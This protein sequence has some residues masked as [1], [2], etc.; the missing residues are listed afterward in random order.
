MVGRTLGH[1]KILEPLGAGGMGEVYRARDSKLDRDVAIKVLPQDFAADAERLARFTREAKLLASLNHPGIAGVYGLEDE[2]ATCFIAMELVEGETLADRIARAG[3]IEVDEALEIARQIAAALEAAHGKGVI[4]RDL[5]PANVIVTKNGKA[6]V[7]DF[8]LAKALAAGGDGG[9]AD[10]TLSPTMVSAV[11]AAGMILGTAAY[12]SPEQARGQAADSRADVWSFGVV[13]FEMLSGKRLFPGDT[14]S[15]VLASVLKS[16]PEWNHLPTDLPAAVHRLLRRCLAKDSADRLHHIADARLDI[17]DAL[18][19]SSPDEVAVRVAPPADTLRTRFLPWT[20]AGVAILLAVATLWFGDLLSTAESGP[21][22]SLA[23]PFPPGTRMFDDQ[24]GALAVSPSGGHLA[25]VLFQDGVRK[26]FLR[27]LDEPGVVPLEGTEGAEMPFFSPDGRWLGF[28]ADGALRKVPVDGGTPLTVCDCVENNRGASWGTGDSIVFAPENATPLMMVSAGGGSPVTI[29]R[30]DEETGERTHRWPQVL[31]D[32]DA[33][34]FTVGYLDS[35]ESYEESPIDAVRISTGER[36]RILEG[37]SFAKYVASGHLLFARGGSLFAIR[38]DP[39]VLETRG[40]PVRVME[41][42]TGN[43]NSGVAHVDIS[44]GGLLAF[45]P[46]EQTQLRR[47]L[48]WAKPGG[49]REPLAMPADAYSN[50]RVSPDGSRIAFTVMGEVSMDMWIH[51]LGDE[52]TARLTFMGNDG[53][54]AWSP[55]GEW[56]AFSSDRGGR[57][58]VYR[59]RSDGSGEAELLLASADRDYHPTSWSADG[60]YLALESYAGN[61]DISTLSL[62]E[63]RAN[64]AF[65]ST[66]YDESMPSFSPD[67]RWLAYRSDESSQDEIYVKPFPGP[68]AKRQVSV[69]GGTEPY[70]SRDGSRLFYRSDGSI[71]AVD[72]DSD[73]EGFRSGRPQLIVENVEQLRF[74]EGAIY[75]VDTNGDRFLIFAPADE[76]ESGP[77]RVEV[78][79]NWFDSLRRRLAESSR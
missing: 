72:I 24:G 21:S 56:V 61:W 37:A 12:M 62:D 18:S 63:D 25:V 6:K 55:G 39:G 65:L 77:D 52:T 33:V 30:L 71:W 36:K 15:D 34:L 49:G 4:H 11:S 35:S 40:A 31:P 28:V 43:R 58:A 8:G 10:A 74:G 17:R 13:L 45:I 1:Y 76:G 38:F 73:G 48:T 78:V 19:D 9:Q 29:T 26:I 32:G 53:D 23:V 20:V 41:G 3:R 75:S 5:K 59:K 46:G 47:V 42:V 54:A 7:L 68:G 44:A 57:S 51:N 16:E 69:D 14:V 22:L 70:W 27:A 67:G 2:G 60:R 64:E 66:E 50:P 79:V